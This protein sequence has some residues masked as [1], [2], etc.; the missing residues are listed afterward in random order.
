MDLADIVVVVVGFFND[1]E[2]EPVKVWGESMV[3]Q[4]KRRED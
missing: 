2:K 1:G 3:D 4:V